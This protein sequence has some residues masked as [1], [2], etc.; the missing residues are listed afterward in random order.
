MQLREEQK[1]ERRARIVA[2]AIE[3]IEEDGLDALTMGKV[4]RKARVTAPTIYNLVGNREAVLAAVMQAARQRFLANLGAAETSPTADDETGV[5]SIVEAC[6]QELADGARLYLPI[7]Q[8]AAHAGID[9]TDA[10][11][12]VL[13][14]RIRAAVAELASRGA[15]AEWADVELTTQRICSQILNAGW[16]WSLSYLSTESMQRCIVY[17]VATHLAGVCEGPGRAQFVR[18]ARRLQQA[19]LS[20]VGL[21]ASAEARASEGSTLG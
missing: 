2:A 5:I 21:P 18:I 4:A 13:P 15:L 17:D 14:P 3:L 7:A 1:A 10:L 20:E 12:M 9:R 19:G 16:R 6:V 8:F 11:M